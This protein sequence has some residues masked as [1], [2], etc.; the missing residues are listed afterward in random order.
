MTDRVSQ[1]AEKLASYLSRRVFL[2]GL[3]RSALAVPWQWPGWWGVC[4]RS[5]TALERITA[6]AA[7]IPA[8]A[9]PLH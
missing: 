3:G 6:F 8:Q 5:L 9:A 7:I 4:S 2:S 1:K